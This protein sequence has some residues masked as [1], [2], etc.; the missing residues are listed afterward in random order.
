VSKEQSKPQD[1][2]KQPEQ[3][4]KAKRKREPMEV[5]VVDRWTGNKV[6]A[7]Y[8]GEVNRKGAEPRYKVYSPFFVGLDRHFEA[9]SADL[10][11][12]HR[13]V[14]RSE[15][16]FRGLAPDATEVEEFLKKDAIVAAD[17][18]L[19]RIGMGFLAPTSRYPQ[20]ALGAA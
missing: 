5:L 8:R 1:P 15:F 20:A 9:K 12:A 11:K 18:E 13:W 17:E 4:T 6:H 16:T 3:A 2:V 7:E 14:S 19:V 10:G